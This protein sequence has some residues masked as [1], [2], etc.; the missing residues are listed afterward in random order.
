MRTK[1]FIA[2]FSLA[3]SL[4]ARNNSRALP[5]TT[6]QVELSS[7][8]E[9]CLSYSNPFSNFLSTLYMNDYYTGYYNSNNYP[10]FPVN[11]LTIPSY[12]IS[13]KYHPSDRMALRIGLDFNTSNSNF[14]QTSS[15][16]SFPPSTTESYGLTQ[17]GTSIGMEISRG[18]GKTQWFAGGDLF[19]E[20]YN[21]SSKFTDTGT[22]D[23]YTLDCNSF[24][25][26]PLIG[27]RYYI[28]K[29]ISVSA[30]SKL[31]IYYNHYTVDEINTS[32]GGNASFDTYTGGGF[33]M[34]ISPIAQL[35]VNI[36]F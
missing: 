9:L 36:H 2:L 4:F 8:H 20:H 17:F 27:V 35:G 10:F 21:L 22:I 26:A 7:K 33:N 6:K 16:S 14:K 28:S 18:E 31:N 3:G 32:S 15:S 24:G 23:N 12:G 1:L 13:Y 11:I 25:I 19:Y 29:L 5:D 30:E 34:K